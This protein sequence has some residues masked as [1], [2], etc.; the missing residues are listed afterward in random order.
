[1]RA[2]HRFIGLVTALVVA[3]ASGP[4]TTVH[5]ALREQPNTL[6]PLVSTQY[7]E[8]YLTEGIFSGLTKLDDHARVQPDLALTVPTVANGGISHD[9][10][11]LTYHL[12]PNAR[13]QDG[14]PVT[15][16]DV[17]FTFAK[18]RDN[19]VP[20]VSR[21]LYDAVERV[22]ARDAH[23][24]VVH[25]AH[26]EPD[27]PYEIFVAGQNGEIVP[28]HLLDHVDDM[29]HAPFNAAPIGSGA[30]RV[31][32]WDRGT[33]VTLIA[34]PD[35]FLGPPP[36]DR[37]VVSFIPDSNT[38][39]LSV[40]SHTSDLA[41]I[42]PNNVAAASATPGIRVV[43]MVQPTLVYLHFRSDVPP[44]D[45]LHLRRA[46]ALP[47]D[48]IG[49]AQKTYLGQAE[50]AT[51]IVLPESPFH[52]VTAIP[53][54]DLAAARAELEA[55]GW[56]VGPDGIRQRNGQRLSIVLTCVAQDAALLRGAVVLQSVWRDL[57]IESDVRPLPAN[58]LY[59]P[60]GT[61]ASGNFSVALV[62]YSFSITPDRSEWLA[63]D[64]IPPNG[65]NYARLRDPA[66]DR[67]MN[68][69]HYTVDPAQRKRDFARIA[70]RVDAELPVVPLVWTKA[71]F[72]VASRIDGIRP[73]PVNS[74][75][76][77]VT[78]W[79]VH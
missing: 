20:Y 33:S 11:T 75:L 44:F 48:R 8:N 1:M 22:E 71:V 39:A 73:E 53:R 17:V 67:L 56:H 25:L 32:Q 10:R 13:W 35:Y 36:I 45:D 50:P 27:A 41:Q 74:D 19:R 62:T 34:N 60:A 42:Q 3:G 38:R 9:G 7:D 28:K 79:R 2:L 69:A 68:A 59:G 66:L 70:A 12:R 55:A 76:W 15:A 4:P 14:V 65:Y 78:T 43:S 64:A 31:T 52:T 61:L 46:L 26:A 40:L 47:I 57:G 16:D 6:N 51:D 58:L 30:Y 21:A 29:L 23:T 49:L 5:I 54:P 72:A 63:S 24:V 18:I 77:N 37:I